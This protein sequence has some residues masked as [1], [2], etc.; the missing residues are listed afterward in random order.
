M[1]YVAIVIVAAGVVAFIA[2]PL[3]VRPDLLGEDAV[4]LGNANQLNYLTAKKA[5]IEENMRELEFERQMG[6][7]SSEDYA[8][9][10]DGYA[11]E[12]E[13]VARAMERFKARQEI[14]DLIENEVRSRRR[15]K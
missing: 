2:R 15:T 1:E 13:D 3:F 6:K 12:M 7:L 5:R 8:A 10:K 9:L 4:D 11:S 14:V